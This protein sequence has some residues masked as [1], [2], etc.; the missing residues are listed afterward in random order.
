MGN[1]AVY[2]S[3]DIIIEDGQYS[4]MHDE[5][6]MDVEKL[7]TETREREPE[8]MKYFYGLPDVPRVMARNERNGLRGFKSLFG[9]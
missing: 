6:M 5:R 8:L 2:V 7:V 9:K 3:I 4:W 1:D